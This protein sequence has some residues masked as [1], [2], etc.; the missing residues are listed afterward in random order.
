MATKVRYKAND[1][2]YILMGVGYGAHR[3]TRPSPFLGNLVPTV[4]DAQMEMIAVCDGT[5]T[6]YWASSDD[7]EAIEVDGQTPRELL[8]GAN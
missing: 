5:G 6:V 3:A 4:D 8:D 2:V 1:Q 7:V